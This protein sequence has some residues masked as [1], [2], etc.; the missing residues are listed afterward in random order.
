VAT[1]R[2]DARSSAPLSD[3]PASETPRVM[4]RVT[5]PRQASE[6]EGEGRILV[7]ASDA[8]QSQS[9]LQPAKLGDFRVTLSGSGEDWLRF[10]ELDGM[11]SRIS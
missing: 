3:W 11:L 1:G 6:G 10:G 9:Q 5:P 8:S 2:D 4:R 7:P